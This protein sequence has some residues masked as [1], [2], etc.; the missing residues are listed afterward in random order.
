MKIDLNID[1][2]N[3]KDLIDIFD[4]NK[5]NFS[6]RDVISVKYNN[7]VGGIRGQNISPHEKSKLLDFI[8]LAY[9]K[10]HKFLE[11]ENN[12]SMDKAFLNKKNRVFE[13]ADHQIIKSNNNVSHINP[14]MQKTMTK[15]ININTKFRKNYYNQQSTNFS[16]DLTN[17]LKNVISMSLVSIQIPKNSFYPISSKLQTNEFTMIFYSD[18]DTTGTPYTIKIMDGVYTGIQLQNYLNEYVFTGD[19]ENQD[20]SGVVCEMDAITNKFRFYKDVRFA[21]NGGT[22]VN[23][24]DVSERDSLKKFDID[25]RIQSNKDRPIQFNLGWLLG[26]KKQYYKYSDDYVEHNKVSFDKLEGY[27]SDSVFNIDDNYFLLSIDD[28]N[29]NHAPLILS[30]FQQS[31]FNDNNVLAIIPKEQ[32]NKN[33]E[34]INYNAGRKYFGPVTISKLKVGLLDQYGRTVDLNDSDF[35]FTLKVE[36]LYNGNN[37]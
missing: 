29:N 31:V 5:E 24:N 33:Y 26:Y 10:I 21:N 15:L 34:D 7:L 37:F 11:I 25:W 27:S 14:I 16:F 8:N 36:Q 28:Y 30:P 35:S 4:L 6:N 9:G 23:I 22:D 12:I 19:G 18:S 17:E 2:Y 1:K 3:L 32:D 20:L 13:T